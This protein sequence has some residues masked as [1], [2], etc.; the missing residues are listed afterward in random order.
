MQFS[1]NKGIII[2]VL[3]VVVLSFLRVLNKFWFS[4]CLENV[5]NLLCACSNNI[6]MGS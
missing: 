3:V 6:R 4:N 1:G 2:V 5:S